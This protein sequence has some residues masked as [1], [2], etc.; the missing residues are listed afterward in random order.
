MPHGASKAFSNWRLKSSPGRSCGPAPRPGGCPYGK[1]LDGGRE[2][3]QDNR[4]TTP[5]QRRE[6]GTSE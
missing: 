5:P 3:G 6:P 4:P 2:H 1:A